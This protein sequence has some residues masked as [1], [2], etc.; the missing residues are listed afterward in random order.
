MDSMKLPHST[1]KEKPNKSLELTGVRPYGS[2][3]KVDKR[4]AVDPIRACSSTLC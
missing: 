4:E 1:A 2:R 3:R